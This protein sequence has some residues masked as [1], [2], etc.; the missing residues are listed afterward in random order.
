MKA[1][2]KPPHAKS[3]Y[4]ARETLV[5]ALINGAISVGFF[6]LVFGGLDPI[7]LRGEAAD[8]SMSLAACPSK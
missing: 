4:I 2:L 3:K 8:L 7:P 1:A 5:S 6:V